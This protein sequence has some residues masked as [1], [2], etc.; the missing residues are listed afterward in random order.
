MNYKELIKIVD[1][2]HIER[3]NNLYEKYGDDPK[4]YIAQLSR[5]KGDKLSQR[6]GVWLNKAEE[7][8]LEKVV[9]ALKEFNPKGS[10][11]VAN[12]RQMS[13]SVANRMG[14][15]GEDW[16]DISFKDWVNAG[17]PSGFWFYDD[18]STADARRKISAVERALETV[19]IG[20]DRY[21]VWA[22]DSSLMVS[23]EPES[24]EESKFEPSSNEELLNYIESKAEEARDLVEMDDDGFEVITPGKTQ[25][26]LSYGGNTYN[27]EI[28]VGEDETFPDDIHA[29]VEGGSPEDEWVSDSPYTLALRVAEHCLGINID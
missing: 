21:N 8:G 11:S 28:V 18:L 13:P 20:P 10:A 25:F 24:Q 27:I 4:N 17:F 9:K 16:E 6:L 23:V 2:S 26:A 29:Y 12:N 3:F 14:H 15:Y 19:G 5:C 7:L 22:E 1:A